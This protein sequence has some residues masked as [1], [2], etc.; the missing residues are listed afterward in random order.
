MSLSPRLRRVLAALVAL[1]ATG[2]TLTVVATGGLDENGKPQGTVTVHVARKPV[3]DR[4]AR[5][6]TPAG[7]PAATL[8]AGREQQDALAATDQLPIVTPLAAPQQRGCTTRMVRNFSTRRGVR[9][10]LL[11]AHYTVS[12]AGS[13]PA[14]VRLFDTASFAASSNYVIDRD[15]SCWYI[16]NEADKA[17]TQ[18]AANPVSIS[19]EF[20]A[21]GTEGSLSPAQVAKGGQVFADAAHRWN[22]PIQFG[23]VSGCN[24]VRGGLVDHSMLGLCGGGHHDIKPFS[25]SPLMAAIASHSRPV[26]ATDRLTCSRLQA[27]R[28]RGRPVAEVATNIRRRDA[29]ASRGVTCDARGARRL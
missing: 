8:E 24:V 29:L 21:M 15:G 12:R 1:V 9:P 13:G 17:W 28:R 10:R 26:T 22:I 16:V 19:I 27:W 5:D 3:A 11:V 7:V 6:E 4:G 25:L 20:V 23:A 14:I 2:V 18:A